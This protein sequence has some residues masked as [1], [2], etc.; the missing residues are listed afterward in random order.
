MRLLTRLGLLSS[1]LSALFVYTAAADPISSDLGAASNGGGCYPTGINPALFDM[2]TLVNPEWASLLDGTHVDSDPVLVHATVTGMHGDTGGDFPGTHVRSDVNYFLKVD[3]EDEGLVASNNGDNLEFEWEA[4]AL[5]DWA[6]AGSGD[7]VVA[8]GRWIFDCGHPDASAGHCSAQSANAC[9]VDADCKKPTCPTCGSGETCVGARFGYSSELHPPYAEAVIR[10]GRGAPLGDAWH[11]R[12]VPATRVDIFVSSNGGGAG[13]RC[14]LTHL[15]DF[16][17]VFSTDC[18]PLADPVADVNRRD[19]EFDV[20][21]PQKPAHGKLA[22]RRESH[23]TPGGVAARLRLTPVLNDPSPHL[24]ARLLLTGDPDHPDAP[25]PTGYAGTIW[26]GWRNDPT[27]LTHVRVTITGV[28]IR[29]A[30][31]RVEPISPRICN[32]S[33]DECDTTA[34]CGADGGECQGAGAVKAWQL[35]VGVDGNWHELPGLDSVESSDVI[36]QAIVVDQYLPADGALHIEMDGSARECVSTMFGKSLSTDI[37]ELGLSTG[38]ECL[39]STEHNPGR[40]DVSYPGPEFGSGERRGTRYETA[41]SGG[42]GGHCS[43][44]TDLAC[45]VNEDCP[46]ESC[47]TTGSAFA[48]RYR[49]QKLPPDD[50]RSDQ[51]MIMI[52]IM[53][54]ITIMTAATGLATRIRQAR[55]SAGTSVVLGAF[56]ARRRGR[57]SWESRSPAPTERDDRRAV[58]AAGNRTFTG[59]TERYGNLLLGADQRTAPRARSADRDDPQLAGSGTGYA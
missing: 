27:H 57:R 55:P 44:T 38:I 25:L 37:E 28:V 13:D 22:I 29:N 59:D 9:V 18:Y 36:P 14:V 15:P 53:I 5:P 48:L 54:M 1:L 47:V 45:V 40:I 26:A 21:L 35:Q 11:S 31:Q 12:A 32:V 58:A 10:Q 42:E 56:Q 33:G 51:I 7:R 30:L 3:P 41:S 50:G 24:H 19:F 43:V 17:S 49:I 6:W 20:P 16:T 46:G 34:D 4:G 52:M 8:L 39:N 23:A 2:I